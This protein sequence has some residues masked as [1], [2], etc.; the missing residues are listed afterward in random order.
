MGSPQS[1]VF[2]I[3]SSVS[4]IPARFLPRDIFNY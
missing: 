2:T 4:G 3:P 1:F